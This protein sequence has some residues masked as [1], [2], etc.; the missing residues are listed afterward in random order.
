MANLLSEASPI[1]TFKEKSISGNTN[2]NG[3]VQ[4]QTVTNKESEIASLKNEIEYLRAQN[5]ELLKIIGAKM[6]IENGEINCIYIFFFKN[7]A[8]NYSYVYTCTLY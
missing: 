8:V 7:V 1:I 3:Y 4:I 5:Q 6:I 2:A